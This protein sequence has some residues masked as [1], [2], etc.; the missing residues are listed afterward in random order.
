[1]KNSRNAF[2]LIELLVVIA[3]LALLAT[4]LGPA[5]KSIAMGNATVQAS[6]MVTSQ[7]AIARQAAITKNNPVE[8]RFYKM[9]DPSLPG[10]SL[11]DQKSWKVR[12][13]QVFE[14]K[15]DGTLSALSKMQKLPDSAII[16]SDERWSSILKS[17][18][19]Q[20]ATVSL[21]GVNMSYIYY[22]IRFRPDGSTGLSFAG[23]KWFVT[24]HDRK[25]GDEVDSLPANYATIQ[26]DPIQGST[27]LF[28]PGLK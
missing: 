28:R 27:K 19:E 12:A 7:I 14:V 3:I 4:F 26:I 5:A 1:M 10:E 9:A 22:P 11:S 13:L 16:D 21:P 15:P 18:N 6:Q 23:G 25:L 17:E 24:I 20:Q 8:L 2:S